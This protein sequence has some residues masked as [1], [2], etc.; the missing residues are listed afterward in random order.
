VAIA[1]LAALTSCATIIHP[2]RKGNRVPGDGCSTLCRCEFFGGSGT[3]P[4]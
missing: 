1:T 2:E 3:G 4:G